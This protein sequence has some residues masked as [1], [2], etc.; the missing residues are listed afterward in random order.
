LIT[1]AAEAACDVDGFDEDAVDVLDVAFELAAVEVEETADR[2]DEIADVRARISTARS[3]TAS[4]SE[5]PR[6]EAADPSSPTAVVSVPEEPIA[7][8]SVE[9]ALERPDVIARVVLSRETTTASA[10]SRL[11]VNVVETAAPRSEDPDPSVDVDDA[12]GTTCWPNFAAVALR[13]SIDRARL[14]N[15]CGI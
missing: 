6:T 1:A 11:T 2:S 13:M 5:S 15:A 4:D 14:L 7:E 10:L 8:V 9:D 3:D 12:T